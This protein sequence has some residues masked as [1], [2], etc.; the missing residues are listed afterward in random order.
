MRQSLP[1]RSSV[2]ASPMRWVTRPYRIQDGYLTP[3]AGTV[4]N[5]YRPL[6]EGVESAPEGGRK[7]L[8][9][10]L[11]SL[12]WTDMEELEAFASQW[13]LLGLFYHDLLQ[14][15]FETGSKTGGWRRAWVTVIPDM[16]FSYWLPEQIP[17][18]QRYRLRGSVIVRE[19][20]EYVEEGLVSYA[21]R[22]F[23]GLLP[24]GEV[25]AASS[26]RTGVK[27]L[28]PILSTPDVWDH[29][30]EPV[31]AFQD[32]AEEFRSVYE[33]CARWAD[34]ERGEERALQRAF[35]T[36]LRHVQPLALPP[37]D[38]PPEQE[39]LDASGHRWKAGWS[40][41]SLLAAAYM[42]LFLDLTAG[43]MPRVCANDRCNEVFIA[44]RPD[45]LFHSERC[46]KNA[47]QRKYRQRKPEVG[48]GESHATHLGPRAEDV[49]RTQTGEA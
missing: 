24:D 20:R 6:A 31:A 43:R 9:E 37:T 19:G 36:H 33:L 40:S 22:Y 29:L 48:Q 12:D 44:T 47:K 11:G 30:C 21:S 14:I 41:P 4:P 27:R 10:A 7:F 16:A 2:S 28:V 42:R 26:D 38:D 34:G 8:H 49:G 15:R 3:V 35:W 46:M 17:V 18:M 5:Q 23:P 45:R 25:K 1:D 39:C 32:A 13:G